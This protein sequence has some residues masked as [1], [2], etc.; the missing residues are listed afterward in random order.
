[1]RR[2]TS[3]A[4]R[5]SSSEEQHRLLTTNPRDIGEPLSVEQMLRQKSDRLATLI[6]LGSSWVA[7][8]DPDALL[9]RVVDDAG[10]LTG[11]GSAAIY[12]VQDDTLYLQ[13]TSPAFAADLPEI[14]LR[15]SL[16][17]HPHLQRAMA[18]MA[19]V[20]LPDAR[21]ADLTPAE[22]RVCEAQD[23][24]SLLILPLG[25]DDRSLGV[26]IVGSMGREY[27]FSDEEV[28]VFQTL[29]IRASL[30]IEETRLYTENRR[31][32]A[33]L[34]Q[35]IRERTQVEEALNTALDEAN[36]SRRALLSVLEDQ[37]QSEAAL[38]E[39]QTQF[40]TLFEANPLAI[41][42][43]GV[44]GRFLRCNPT[45]ISLLGYTTEELAALDPTH[46][47]D[48]DAGKAYFARLAAGEIDHYEREKR[49]L[50]RDGQT[51]W[52]HVTATTVRDADDTLL[53]VMLVNRDITAR[54]EAEQ[55]LLESET[56]L[57]LIFDNASDGINVYEEDPTTR[58]RRLVD[59]NERYA[60]MAGRSRAD[61]LTAGTTRGMQVNLGPR[62]TPEESRKL[63]EERKPYRG[64]I[65]WLRPDGKDNVIEYTAV[66]V[67]LG[68]RPLTVG[69]DRDITDRI[70]AEEKLQEYA[71]HLED[72]VAER[73]GELEAAQERLLRQTRL[74][75]L[76]QIA[77]S[78]AHE[79]RTPL[80]AIKNATYLVNML[81]DRDNDALEET[82]DIL[83]Q[84]VN[85]ADHTITTLLDFARPRPPHRQLIRIESI[86]ESALDSLQLSPNVHVD[87]H[88]E[89][90]LPLII[91]DATHLEQVLNN[92]L[93]NA[94]QAMPNGGR[95]MLRT[96]RRAD[97]PDTVPLGFAPEPSDRPLMGWV[98]LSIADTGIG[99][100][101]ENLEHLFEP[102]FTTKP[103]GIGLG[104]AL[105]KLLVQANG[106]GINVKSTPGEGTTFEVFLPIAA[107][108]G[109]PGSTADHSVLLEHRSH[110]E[111]DDA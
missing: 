39:S 28:D 65:S 61:L 26:L 100:A 22:R 9:Q 5:S 89:T 90:H 64:T 1:M 102:L 20:M 25:R 44:D 48:L 15:A 7:I 51:I 35:Q 91:A 31:H 72:L 37:R 79:L 29:A 55:K 52:V 8:R 6:H 99:I 63:R 84:A 24:R 87:S 30:Q 80:G 23:L 59:C 97:L 34:K 3:P 12:F 19:P 2:F 58:T 71:D 14:L 67:E 45:M 68:G 57:R 92:L 109:S 41:G 74:A 42:L 46:P 95:L 103:T 17:E 96:M 49:Y 106:G 69:I 101:P 33:A 40:R 111:A 75:T 10:R 70:R 94:I 76:G 62:R 78:I 56:M 77:G 104:L 66:P 53:Y 13:A 108:H 16:S 11:S 43:Y 60:E 98:V 47:D 38:R 82:L 50:H 88:I 81:V 4:E 105:V 107:E 36:M 21:V 85:T 110:S 86:V 93:L 32:I 73:T 18:T 27:H 54:K 83:A